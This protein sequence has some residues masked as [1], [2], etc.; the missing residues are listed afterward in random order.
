MA[1]NIVGNVSGLTDALNTAQ[2]AV[3]KAADKMKSAGSAL[4]AGVTLPLVG[5]AT[6][7]IASAADFEQTMNVMQQ[8]SGATEAQMA[9]LQAQALE[10][11][12]DTVFSASEAA[13]GMLELA[14]AGLTAEESGQA[15][16][17][18]LD[19]AAAGNLDLAEAATIAANAV[20]A[21]RL[22]ASDTNDVA[23]LLAAAANASSVEVTDLAYGMQMASAVF[24]SNSQ[25]IETLNTALAILGNNGLKGSDAGTSLKTMM[26]RLA[27]P[28]DKARAAIESLGVSMYDAE[29]NMRALPDIMNDLQAALYGTSTVTVTTSNRTAEQAERMDYLGGVIE[30]TQRK[31]A[32]YQSGL[33]GVAQS[34]EDKVVAVDRLN[35][36]LAAAQAE[37]AGLAGIQ[38]STSTVTREFTEEMRNQA[39]ATIFGSDAIRA[40]NILLAEGEEGWNAMASAL[41]NDS[42]A[43]DVANARMKGLAGAFEQFRGT[44]ET[45]MLGAALPFTETLA[46]MVRRLSDL[47]E[48]ITK[49]TPE[50]QRFAAILG[51]VAAAA[52]PVLWALG[53]ITGALGTLLSPIGLAVAAVAGLGVAWSTNFL[54]IRDLTAEIWAAVQPALQAMGVAVEGFYRILATGEP[55]DWYG[56][57]E[58]LSLIVGEEWADRIHAAGET[59]LGFR[60]KATEAFSSLPDA[61]ATVQTSFSTA[62]AS[63]TE[64]WTTVADFFGPSIE[65]VRAAFG[66]L[67]E[68]VS[69]MGPSFSALGTALG[70]LWEAAQPIL[71]GLGQVIAAVFGVASVALIN[72]FAA[73]IEALGPIVETVVNQITTVINTIAGVLSGATALVRAVIDG[74][75][76]AAWEAGKGIVDTMKEG[77]EDTINNLLE[78]VTTIFTAIYEA[79][80]ATLD[81]L[82]LDVDTK[83]N[84]LLG[85]WKG[86]WESLGQAV[87]PVID[88]VATVKE[89][90]ETFIGWITNISIPNPFEGW[91]FPSLPGWMGGGGTPPANQLGTSYWRGGL[92]MVGEDGPE[93]VWLPMGSQ[94]MGNTDFRRAMLGG[95]FGGDAAINVGPVYVQN[96][97]DAY[98]IGLMARNAL[99]RG[100]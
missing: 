39:L 60:Q 92:T 31:L 65:R 40:A 45:L 96:D 21:F 46:D 93:P 86:I 91:S 58:E 98:Q 66:S 18:V 99:R 23:N 48:G 77:M 32:D 53:A 10:L 52:G 3:G 59:L 72:T 71:E 84:Q 50:Q 61:W 19:L 78:V 15:I 4:T 85:F 80:T 49:L 34:E 16:A 11:G 29:G 62:T 24:A 17:G 2:G 47:L 95:A 25:S 63:L 26:M 64:V 5:V 73:T 35:R 30:R 43:A 8:V 75:W 88:A 13:A 74:D 68:S 7:A 56:W 51:V 82:G 33:A 94:I 79:V 55:G 90:I 87:Q 22:E 36:E 37:Y 42:A 27:A 12:A 67:G 57:W 41:D 89:A 69:G 6:A 54:G 76:S 38:D 9:S 1:I 20:N 14:K 70:S 97:L 81:D 28:T 100:Y 44:I 83:M